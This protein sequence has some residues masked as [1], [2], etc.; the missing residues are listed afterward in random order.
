[1]LNNSKMKT[2]QFI[3]DSL[4]SH[5]KARHLTYRHIAEKLGVSEQPKAQGNG[6]I[7]GQGQATLATPTTSTANPNK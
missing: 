4:R 1:M 6:Q 3:F 2:G 7:D 5:L